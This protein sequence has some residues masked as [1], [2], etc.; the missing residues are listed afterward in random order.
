MK[1]ERKEILAGW[2]NYPKE[3]C[4]VSRPETQE[5]LKAKIQRA[6]CASY[7]SYGLGRS[8]GDAPL[9]GN[10]GV[11]RTVHMNKL[12]AFDADSGILNCE[13]GVTFEEIIEIFLPKGFFLPVTPGTK[14]V[15]V[16]GAIAN[17]VHG[18]NHHADGCFSEHVLSFQLLIADGS[19]MQCS[20]E[21][22]SDLFWATVGGIG[23]TGII[24]TAKFRLIKVESSYYHVKYEKAKNI[25]EALELFRESDANYQYSVA[26]IDCLAKGNSLGKSVL[27]RGNHARLEDLSWK[28]R[29]NPLQIKTNLKLS[30]PIN[31]PPFVLNPYSI[32]LFNIAY[33][34]IQPSDVNKVVHFD[35]FFYPLDSI[36]NWN[37][38]YG[39]KGFVQYQAVFPPNEIEGLIK[40]LEKLSS[41]NR[42]SFLA[43]LKSS[44]RE[45]QG[46]LS[47]PKK[48]YTLALDIPIKDHSLFPFLRELDELVIKHNGRV[49]LAKDSTLAPEK[50]KI[51]YPRLNEFLAIKN[52]VDPDHIFSSSMARRLNILEA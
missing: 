39:K 5:Q 12:I 27:M 42:S 29:I 4:F 30:M 34:G 26:W 22:N 1:L 47:F 35:S 46:M 7:I 20:R 16:G 48:G 6:S 21:T 33:Y 50:C 41:T 17:D 18:K 2:G 11:I 51:M 36:M 3:P 31:M 28:Q 38:M 9:N 43:V 15:T 10:S 13:A 49:Y 44:G 19:I 32:K 40:M 52:K 24:L 25:E 23:L 8:Y 37:R 14:F 45:G